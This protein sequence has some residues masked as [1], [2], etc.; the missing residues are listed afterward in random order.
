MEEKPKLVKVKSI[1][2][3]KTLNFAA[4]TNLSLQQIRDVLINSG[5]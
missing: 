4:K 1:D 3:E 5:T 2:S